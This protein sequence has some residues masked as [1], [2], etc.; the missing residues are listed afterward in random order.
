MM[1][2][3]LKNR[4]IFGDVVFLLMTPKRLL[5]SSRKNEV[6]ATP[7]VYK[8]NQNRNKKSCKHLHLFAVT[9]FVIDNLE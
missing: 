8:K 3:Q 4:A 1:L 9:F 2:L 6:I 5:Q 7:E